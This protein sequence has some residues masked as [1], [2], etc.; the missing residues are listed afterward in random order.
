MQFFSFIQNQQEDIYADLQPYRPPSI[1][2]KDAIYG[3]IR[4]FGIIDIPRLVIRLASVVARIE[5]STIV[6]NLMI[7]TIYL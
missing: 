7:I 4:E 3:M 2:N 1:H 6:I 5:I